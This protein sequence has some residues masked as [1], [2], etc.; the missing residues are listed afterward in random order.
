MV[1]EHRLGFQGGRELR[2]RLAR[3][4]IEHDQTAAPLAQRRVQRG[5]RAQDEVDAPVR[6]EAPFQQGIE[7][8]AVEDK[9]APYLSAVLKGIMQRRVVVGAQVAPE[10]DQAAFE[11][12]VDTIRRA[13]GGIR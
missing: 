9:H 5:Q 6:L 1:G 11:A 2:D 10:P 12:L 7:D 8:L 13:A 4:G 3:H